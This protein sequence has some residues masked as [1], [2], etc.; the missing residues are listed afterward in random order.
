MSN[1]SNEHVI[2]QFVAAI[3]SGDTATLAAILAPDATWHLHGRLPVA[4]HYVGRQAILNDF[5]RQGL[6]LYRAGSLKLDLTRIVSDGDV[7]AIEW[8]AVGTSVDGRAYDNEYAFFFTVEHS[9][10]TSI[11]EY[12]DTLHVCDALYAAHG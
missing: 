2:R 3:E 12:C 4:G 1:P 5:L 9:R 10:I 7:V 8:N 11:R 6:G